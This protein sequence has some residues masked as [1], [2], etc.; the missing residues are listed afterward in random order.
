MHIP[1]GYAAAVRAQMSHGVFGTKLHLGL[2]GDSDKRAAVK[3]ENRNNM[4]GNA[5]FCNKTP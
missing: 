3:E 4:S 2:E 1:G 5:T